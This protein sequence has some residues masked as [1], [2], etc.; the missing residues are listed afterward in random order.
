MFKRFMYRFGFEDLLFRNGRFLQLRT[1]ELGVFGFGAFG[2]VG[3]ET[4]L[5]ILQNTGV[6]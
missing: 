1:G 3:F 5:S 2:I 4:P 6:L